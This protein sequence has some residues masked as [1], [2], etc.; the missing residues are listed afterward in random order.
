MKKV[1]FV[2]TFTSKNTYKG[3]IKLLFMKQFFTLVF[4]LCSCLSFS[5]N[6]YWVAGSSFNWNNTAN[7]SLTFPISSK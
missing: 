4:L 2:A 5:A 6:R 7:W 3:K 1:V